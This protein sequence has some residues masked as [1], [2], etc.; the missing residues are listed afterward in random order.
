MVNEDNDRWVKE[1]EASQIIGVSPSTLQ[2]WRCKKGVGPDYSKTGRSVY[3]RVRD[4][5]KW[6]ESHQQTKAI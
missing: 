4:L 1:G 3:Y 6:M 5:H 2:K